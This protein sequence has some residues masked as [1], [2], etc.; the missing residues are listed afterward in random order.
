M[1]ALE[2]RGGSSQRP[3]RQPDSKGGAWR[4]SGTVRLNS[5]AVR[6]REVANDRQ[7]QTQ[8][9]VYPRTR[10]VRLTEAI[11]YMRKEFGIN[12]YSVI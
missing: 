1:L 12:P 11:K 10:S 2:R 9:A 5:P 8:T 6:L 4:F 7:T 3:Q